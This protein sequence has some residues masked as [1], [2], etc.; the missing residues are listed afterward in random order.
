MAIVFEDLI[1]DRVLEGVFEDKNN[2]LIGALNDLQN[3]SINTTA[4][5]KDKTNSQGVLIKRFFTSKSVEV[6]SESAVVSLSL[7]GLQM[8]EGKIVASADN[9]IVLPR[10]KQ[11]D[12]SASPITLPEVP[13]DGTLTVVGCTASGLPATEL[14]YT[15]GDT[16]GAGVYAYAT[17]E[18]DTGEVDEESNPI[19]KT[20]ATITLPTDAAE[21]V[22]IKYDYETD[23]G[24]KVVQKSDKFPAECKLTLSVLVSDACD[25]EVLRHAYIVF[26]AFQMSPDFDLTLDTESAHPFSGIAAVDYCSKDKQLFYIAISDDDTE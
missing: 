3:T 19:M 22:Q 16:A 20:V 24:V 6:S 26:P 12:K 9:K 18:V 13:I 25:K 7:A 15:L 21:T 1:I 10:I 2:N 5:T 14:Q 4:E 8:G 23:K 11:Y 17:S